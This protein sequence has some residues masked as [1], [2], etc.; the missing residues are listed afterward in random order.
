MVNKI[1]K[2]T[3]V[4][5]ETKL[6]NGVFKGLWGGNIIIVEYNLESY[7]LETEIIVKGIN[8]EVIV[9]VNDNSLTF[10]TLNNQVL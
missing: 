8:I 4:I 7:E 3:K 6:P 10:K 1:I 9:T 5:P 2:I